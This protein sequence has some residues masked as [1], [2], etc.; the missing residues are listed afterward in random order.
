MI[1]FEANQSWHRVCFEEVSMESQEV[2]LMMEC[3]T[4]QKLARSVWSVKP[5]IVIGAC[6]FFLASSPSSIFAMQ[7]LS[8]DEDTEFA[9]QLPTMTNPTDSIGSAHFSTSGFAPPTQSSS[10]IGFQNTNMMSSPCVRAAME[11]VRVYTKGTKVLVGGY[12]DVRPCLSLKAFD[13]AYD[14]YDHGDSNI[15][16]GESIGRRLSLGL[17]YAEAEPPHYSDQDFEIPDHHLR[18]VLLSF[19]CSEMKSLDHLNGRVA[20]DIKDPDFVR[21]KQEALSLG[22][23]KVLS[24]LQHSDVL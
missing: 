7:S 14:K 12:I 10:A 6:L 23:V 1:V 4:V 5:N 13:D 11:G 9:E 8:D 18:L 21:C 24:G 3:Q 22:Q 17:D 16:V 2:N 20:L 15:N 19:S